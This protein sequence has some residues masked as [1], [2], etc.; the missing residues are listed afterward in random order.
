MRYL[1]A[2][3]WLP[4]MA[5]N[6]RSS[7]PPISGYEV[8]RAG[9]RISVDGV[10]DE[11]S[12]KQA[13]VIQYRFPWEKQTGA[14]Q[15]TTARMLWD[16][17]YLYIAW[18]AEDTD[19]VAHYG[20]PDDPTYLDDAV[21]LFINPDPKQNWY[22]GLEINAR[23]TV[24]DY[25][26]AFPTKLLKRVNFEGIQIASYIRGTMNVR[27]DTDR[28]W[29]IELAVPWRNFIELAPDGNAPKAGATWTANFN[30]WD[31]VAPDRRLSQW[32]DSGLVEPT[33]HNPERFGRLVFVQ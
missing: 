14:R 25:F 28:G 16:D 27:G 33:P 3:L 26:Y 23:A 4:L 30:R 12:W 6:L 24:Y 29:T 32:S 13:P 9:S 7:L 19:I 22:Y 18:E 17:K 2:L 15:S 10:L 1:G 5:Q 20:S 21:E 31:G 8:H 11:A